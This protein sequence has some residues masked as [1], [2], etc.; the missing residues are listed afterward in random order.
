MAGPGRIYANRKHIKRLW[1][2]LKKWR[3][4]STRYEQHTGSFFVMLCL[5]VTF[6]WI[7]I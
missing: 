5:T 4:V 6:D 3:M 7:K 2:R 1:S